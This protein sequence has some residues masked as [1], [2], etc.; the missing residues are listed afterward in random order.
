MGLLQ[1]HDACNSSNHTTGATGPERS[2]P[3]KNRIGPRMQSLVYLVAREPGIVRLKAA[4]YIGPHGSTRYGY[5]TIARA[6]SAGIV[7]LEW[8][9]NRSRL[10]PV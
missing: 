9:G 7:R 10:Y 6:L 2:N 4:K 8:E 3:M 1:W 5:R